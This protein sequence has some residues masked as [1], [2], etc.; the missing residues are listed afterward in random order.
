MNVTDSFNNGSIGSEDSHKFS[1][2]RRP[3][4]N[5]RPCVTATPVDIFKYIIGPVARGRTKELR[6][7]KDKNEARKYKA[8]QFDYCTFSGVF[9]T[10]NKSGLLQPSNLLCL[11][12][13]HVTDHDSLKERLLS[14]PLFETELLFVSPSGDGLKWVVAVDYQGFDHGQYFDAVRNYLIGE[15]IPEPD[16]ACR[17]ITRSCFLPY[18][19]DVFINPKYG[20]HKENYFSAWEVPEC[21][22]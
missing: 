14:D 19:P 17:D 10:R 20:I 18:D 5:T 4:Q 11:D 13:D 15:G 16:G 2:F 12:F 21:P 9:S 7:I 22:F 1:Y 8:T 6:S 3:I